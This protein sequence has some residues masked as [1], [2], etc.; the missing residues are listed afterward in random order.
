MTNTTDTYIICVPQYL[1]LNIYIRFNKATK[2]IIKNGI[3][4]NKGSELPY[5]T[6]VFKDQ[7]KDH[8]LIFATV[9][10][11]LLKGKESL[12]LLLVVCSKVCHNS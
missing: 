2:Y 7:E 1:K 4:S 6:V 9:A 10:R 11:Y 5:N 3:I 12:L 8:S